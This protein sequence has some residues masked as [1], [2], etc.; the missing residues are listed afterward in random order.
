MVNKEFDVWYMMFDCFDN[1]IYI[2]LIVLVVDY[3]YVYLIEII[4]YEFFFW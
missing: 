3:I 1:I 2:M 4:W